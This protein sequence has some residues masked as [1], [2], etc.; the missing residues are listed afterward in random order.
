MPISISM[1]AVSSQI[2]VADRVRTFDIARS[3]KVDAAAT[4]GIRVAYAKIGNRSGYTLQSVQRT[5]G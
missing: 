5:V 2:V 4:E 3:C 1:I